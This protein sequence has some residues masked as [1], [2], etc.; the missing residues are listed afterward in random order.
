MDIRWQIAFTIYLLYFPVWF[1][2]GALRSRKQLKERR[3]ADQQ[4]K[5]HLRKV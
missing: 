4:E 5:D 2:I 1:F 3:K